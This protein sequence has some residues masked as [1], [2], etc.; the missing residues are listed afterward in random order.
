LR[1]WRRDSARKPFHL[2]ASSAIWLSWRGHRGSRPAV[3]SPQGSRQPEKPLFAP[4]ALRRARRMGPT[5]R[6]GNSAIG[7]GGGRR[8][9]AAR[10]PPRT[11][12]FRA[13]VKARRGNIGLARKVGPCLRAWANPRATSHLSG[14][15]KIGRGKNRARLA[16]RMSDGAVVSVQSGGCTRAVPD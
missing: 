11:K 9:A 15:G 5:G 13:G 3:A 4:P 10:T 12:H 16:V 6:R 14:R 7:T 8:W 2:A 1:S